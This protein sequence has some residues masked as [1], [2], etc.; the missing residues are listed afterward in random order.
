MSRQQNEM[1]SNKTHTIW[2]MG[3][4]LFAIFF[5]AGN[6]IFQPYLG[7]EVG[8]GWFIAFLG[9]FLVDMGMGVLAILAT[10]YNRRGDIQGVV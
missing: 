10:V 9:F 4:A 8:T 2:I 7:R 3:W 6:L 5:G 1:K